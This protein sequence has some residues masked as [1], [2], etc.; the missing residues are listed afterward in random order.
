VSNETFTKIDVNSEP[1]SPAATTA[2]AE[3]KDQPIGEPQVADTADLPI[4]DQSA[5]RAQPINWRAAL[6]AAGLAGFLA[7]IA[8]SGCG[9]RTTIRKPSPAISIAGSSTTLSA[10]AGRNLG[11][12]RR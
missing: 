10:S 7:A 5:D 2:D 12:A 9:T 11:P 3:A 6:S 1:G 4:F 8:G